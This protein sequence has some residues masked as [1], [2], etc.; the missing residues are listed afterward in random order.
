MTN[1]EE[2]SI[3]N[4]SGRKCIPSNIVLKVMLE[5]YHNSRKINSVENNTSKCNTINNDKEST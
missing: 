1:V 3:V 2:N 5:D 4:S